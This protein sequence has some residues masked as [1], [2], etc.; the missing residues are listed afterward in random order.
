MPAILASNVTVVLAL[1]TLVLAVIPGTHGL[2]ISSAIGLLIALAAVLFMLPPLLAVCCKVFWPVLRAPPRP[3]GSGGASG[4]ASQRASSRAPSS[5]SRQASAFSRSWQSASSEPPSDSTRSR[6]SAC[7]QSRPPASMLSGHFPWAKHSPSSSS[8]R[9][10]RRM[11]S[12]RPCRMSR[13]SCVLT[14]PVLRRVAR[15]RTTA[16]SEQRRRALRRASS[17]SPGAACDRSRSR[18]SG[19][20]RRGAVALTD[21]DARDGNV[22]DLL[23]IAPL[24]WS[25]L[26]RA[27]A[28]AALGDRPRAAAARELCECHRGDRRRRMA[29]PRA[30][31]ASTRSICRC[32]CCHSC[33][34]WHSASTTR[35]SSCT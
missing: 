17:R 2:G 31:P 20:A 29:Q 24:S 5:V 13:A 22:Q 25:W 21:Q 26:H 12:S 28:A 34:S 32:R 6:S 30:R 10:M 7:S 1:L 9:A 35:S 8:R 3:G 11:R 15:P 16:T 23:L 33:S 18:R 19:C 4:A 14:Q 27:G